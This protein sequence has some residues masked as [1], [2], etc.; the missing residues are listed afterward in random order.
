M[1][2]VRRI[3]ATTAPGAVIL[4]RLIVGGV[5]FSEGIQKFLF[6]DQN[7]VGRFVKIGIPSPDITAPFVGVVE[8]VCGA[9]ILV[10]LLTRLAAI[11][12]II[13]MLVAILST[14]IPILLGHGFWGFSLR[15]VS[16]Y[17]FWGMAHEART[18]FAML[19][20]S[21]FLLIVGAGAHSIDAQLAVRPSSRNGM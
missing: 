14:K 21:L 16:Y 7:G 17:G 12:L 15:N 19:L 8:I 6:A 18:D 9:L 1:P 3:V 20:G 13:N 10:G 11:P 5:F 2:L 4:I